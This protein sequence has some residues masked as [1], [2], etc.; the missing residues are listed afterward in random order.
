MSPDLLTELIVSG[1]SGLICAV[2]T[3]LI[4]VYVAKAKLT[5][6]N[7]W[8]EDL[9]NRISRIEDTLINRNGRRRS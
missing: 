3:C 1:V 7:H 6:I 9:K 8:M 2:T 5:D 4:G